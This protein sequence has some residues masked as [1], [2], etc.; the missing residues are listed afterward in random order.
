MNCSLAQPAR[1][2]GHPNDRIGF[3]T[4]R[5]LSKIILKQE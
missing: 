5:F 1:I 3:F 4:G 2:I